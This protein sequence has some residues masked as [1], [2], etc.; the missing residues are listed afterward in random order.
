[1]KAIG[2]IVSILILFCPL[3]ASSS[4]VTRTAENALLPEGKVAPTRTPTKG[5]APLYPPCG[6]LR[7]GMGTSN[8]DGYID[9]A[10]WANATVYDISDT[11][12]QSDGL[13][14]PLGT[15]YMYLMQ[16][17]QCLY[18][19]IDAVGDLYADFYDQA[20][21]YFDDN[22]DGC[23]TESFIRDEGNIWVVDDLSG[24]CYLVWRWWQDFYCAGQCVNCLDYYGYY[25]LLGSEYDI[26]LCCCGLSTAAGHVQIEVGFFFGD[27][28]T[29]DW[30]LQTYL[31]QGETCGFYIYYL[32]Q[33]YYDF[34]GE[35]HLAV[36][37]AEPSG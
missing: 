35:I 37:L 32:D 22:D 13:P 15:V 14:N 34:M 19:G 11:C 2:I 33:Y 18:F 24:I 6:T 31:N 5:V 1:M 8:N 20:G 36:Q 12:G 25:N 28:A 26:P 21:F 7:I 10:E 23:W 4:A 16:D 30:D 3:I 29:N 17:D 9:A 27:A